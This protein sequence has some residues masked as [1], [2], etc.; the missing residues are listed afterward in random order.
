MRKKGKIKTNVGTGTGL[1][2][3][4]Y[5]GDGKNTL[6]SHLLVLKVE[7]APLGSILAMIYA[8][9]H[10]YVALTSQFQFVIDFKSC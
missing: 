9:S 5:G 6:K 1:I 4:Q 7:D 2:G 3:N 8:I 10:S